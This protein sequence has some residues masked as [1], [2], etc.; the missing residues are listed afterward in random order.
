MKE[1]VLEQVVDDYLQTRGYFTMANVRFKPDP[2]HAD[3]EVRQDSVTSDVDVIGFNPRLPLPE[4]V[5]VV[6]CKSWQAG[7]DA[8][9]KLAELR[10]E[11]ANGKRETWRMFRELWVPKW[12]DALRDTIERLTGQRDFAYRIACTT[13]R[14]DNVDAWRNDPTISA[15]L[16]GC[17]FG[18]LTFERMWGEVSQRSSTTPAGSQLGRLAQLMKAAKV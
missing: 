14:N 18:F 11:K 6:S 15:N 17:T 5:M 3:Y 1:D 7:L 12:N 8:T 13:L 2:A 10:G 16:R 9:A 4:R